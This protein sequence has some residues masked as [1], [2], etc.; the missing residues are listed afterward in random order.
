VS[1]PEPTFG[2]LL[3]DVA[4]LMRKRFE[5]SARSAGLGL[6]RSQWQVLAFLAKNQ[7]IQQGAL[8]DL[9]EVEPITLGRI[10]DRL[11]AQELVERRA[12]ATDRRVWLLFLR[13]AA[14]PLLKKMRGLGERVRSEAL[15]GV[16]PDDQD[17][18]MQVLSRMRCNLLTTSNRPEEG[19]E[20]HLG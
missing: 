5:Q 6:T 11:Q 16:A 8:A 18:V 9:L 4:R 17:R 7:G 12:H 15:E 19:Q 10:V 1:G 14:E 20:A 13:P 2:F 3:H